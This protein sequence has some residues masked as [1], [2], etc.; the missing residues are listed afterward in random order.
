[1]MSTNL[2]L[3]KRKFKKFANENNG[4]Y[5]L[6]K[7]SGL[8]HLFAFPEGSPLCIGPNCKFIYIRLHRVGGT[9]TADALG[10]EKLHFTSKEAIN[11]VGKK[12]WND[13]Y[14]FAFVRNPFAKMVSTYNHFPRNDRFQM[15][16]NTI[17]FEDWVERLFSEKK[18]PKYYFSVKFFQPQSD[19]LKDHDGNISIDKVGRH[20]NIREEFKEILDI[21]GLE[22]PLP[23]LN[24]SKKVDYRS[25]YN[26]RSFDLVKNWH[27]EDL[28]N[29]GYSFDDG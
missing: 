29:F 21:I 14:K 1:M 2:I 12:C 8:L 10:I 16:S 23:H 19:W 4:T 7:F 28:D 15:K 22:V 11:V 5:K 6:L 26:E 20:E 13:V 27:Q 17:T 18:D 25:Y 24:S 3:F 9:S